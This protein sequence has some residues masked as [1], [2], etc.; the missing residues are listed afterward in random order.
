MNDM[1]VRPSR[2]TIGERRTTHGHARGRSQSLTYTSWNAMI[3]RCFNKNN[4]NYHRYGGSGITVCER[5]RIFSHFLFDMGE[6][7][8]PKHS[9]DRY[10]NKNGNYEPGNCRWATSSEQSRNRRTTRAVIRSDG[11]RFPSMIEAA[12][13]IGGCRRI[14]RDVCT[15]R[16]KTHRGYGWRFADE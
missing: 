5:W 14:I 2:E 1:A 12:E 15:G 11:V 6:R 7:P 3:T 16:G 9:L 4:H 13:A 8:S 10:P